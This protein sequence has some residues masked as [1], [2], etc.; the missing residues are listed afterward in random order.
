MKISGIPAIPLFH[1]SRRKSLAHFF[2]RRLHE[3]RHDWEVSRSALA[4][5]TGF[6]EET[7]KSYE[8]G[9]RT[10]SYPFLCALH[11]AFGVDV[12]EFLPTSNDDNLS[13]NFLLTAR[14]YPFPST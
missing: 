9:K 5:K 12:Q 10:P 11:R 3:F 1:K 7:I 8:Q 4:Y 2:G 6:S 13:L 14:H